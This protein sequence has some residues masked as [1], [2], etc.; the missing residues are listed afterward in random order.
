MEIASLFVI[1]SIL[2]D[3]TQKWNLPFSGEYAETPG[4]QELGIPGVVCTVG[5]LT[6]SK[7]M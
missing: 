1:I 6:F 5:Y 4:F 7:K 3:F 2:N